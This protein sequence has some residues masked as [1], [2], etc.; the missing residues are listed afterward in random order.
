MEL[1]EGDD[2][3]GPQGFPQSHSRLSAGIS[4]TSSQQYLL[5]SGSEMV[6]LNLEESGSSRTCPLQETSVKCCRRQHEVLVKYVRR[7]LESLGHFEELPTSFLMDDK[8]RYKP[9]LPMQA[10][11]EL[12]RVLTS[13]RSLSEDCCCEL[14][15]LK[16]A[17]RQAEWS[18]T[19]ANVL[20]EIQW[21]TSVVYHANICRN[22]KEPFTELKDFPWHAKIGYQE[23][24]S[25]EKAAEEDWQ[26]LMEELQNWNRSHLCSAEDCGNMHEQ[27]DPRYCLATQAVERW[28]QKKER[29][30][31]GRRNVP[32]AAHA[33]GENASGFGKADHQS[34]LWSFDKEVVKHGRPLGSGASGSVS[35][36]TWLGF[37]YAHKIFNVAGLSSLPAEA[38]ALVKMNHP[39]IV[40]VFA[41]SA[42]SLLMD[43]MCTDLQ[44]FMV[45]RM[46]GGAITRAQPF[47]L[48]AAIDLMLQ[49]ADAMSYLHSQNMAHRDLKSLNIL[50]NSVHTPGLAE[51]G[52]VFAKIADF[53]LAKTKREITRYSHL[54]HDIGT[55]RWMAPEI[56]G[57]NK[58]DL[59]LADA[60]PMKADVYS[61]G[62]V[63]YEILSG[64]VPYSDV[65]PTVLYKKLTAPVPLRPR[66][67]SSC[68]TNLASLICACWDGNPRK[69]PA[70]ADVCRVLRYLKGL[71]MTDLNDS[72]L[73]PSDRKWPYGRLTSM[74]KKQ[75]P[76]GSLGWMRWM[77]HQINSPSL[78][79]NNV[80]EPEVE[81]YHIGPL[82]DVRAVK[83]HFRDPERL[84]L[85]GFQVAF[86]VRGEL[87]ERRVGGGSGVSTDWIMFDYPGEFLVQVEGS[88]TDT[89]WGF[90]LI[91]QFPL[92]QS[93][94]NSLSF[95]TTRQKYGPYG[96]VTA[97]TSFCSDPG[98]VVGFT[99][100][101]SSSYHGEINSLEVHVVPDIVECVRNYLEFK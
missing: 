25:L 40:K 59:H 13:A 96:T 27:R 79:L 81:S 63:C 98:R 70:F 47:S 91:P 36:A 75:G 33:A 83:L 37:K 49:V 12:K 8:S 54:T 95:I 74:V 77:W 15:P 88:I 26:E 55:R 100:Y 2:S 64:E 76:W 1:E 6:N 78:I 67:P 66:L 42:D 43:L 71:L 101:H 34:L 10:T 18:Q 90:T 51:E 72:K 21:C 22:V 85:S 86:D 69:R 50:V 82:V 45:S 80:R 4:S 20:K 17:L 35:E 57:T 48:P 30:N 84:H 7:T 73:V 99:G 28:C 93:C 58:D 46:K 19:F 92:I 5:V 32:K 24:F 41:Y 56:F 65:H 16:A 11:R 3:D 94:V 29:K 68:P 60:F 9:S 44:K 52:Y 31:A 53:G 39:H 87:H 89:S 38:G 23:Q 62:I 14:S 97:R 61:F